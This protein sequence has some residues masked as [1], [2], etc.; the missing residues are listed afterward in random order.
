M[1]IECPSQPLH[2]H[3]HTCS[4][5]D[6]VRRLNGH[7]TKSGWLGGEPNNLLFYNN[8]SSSPPTKQCAN[9]LHRCHHYHPHSISTSGRLYSSLCGSSGRSSSSHF[10]LLGRNGEPNDDDFFHFSSLSSTTSPTV[11]SCRRRRPPL[12][13]VSVF[14][15]AIL[16]P[17]FPTWPSAHSSFIYVTHPINITWHIHCTLGH[18]VCTGHAGL[19]VCT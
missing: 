16:P 9:L 13:C 1:K 12:Q 18:N 10:L 15:F 2:T 17:D 7:T 11:V 5:A 19:D 6:Y 4:D 14:L 8:R 3:S